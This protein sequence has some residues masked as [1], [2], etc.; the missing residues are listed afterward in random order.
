MIAL[1]AAL[2]LAQAPPPAAA[3]E[4]EEPPP[5]ASQPPPDP[6]AGGEAEVRAAFDA[7][8]ALRG[9]LEGAWRLNAADGE[10]LYRFQ[11]ADPAGLLDPRAAGPDAPGVEGVWLDARRECALDG[12]GYIASIRARGGLLVLGFSEGRRLA[13]HTVQLKSGDGRWVGWMRAGRARLAVTMTRD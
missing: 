3:P 12:A 4:G 10:L 2:A 13:A 8:Q 11:F 7:G 9:P 1:L 6:N 5:G